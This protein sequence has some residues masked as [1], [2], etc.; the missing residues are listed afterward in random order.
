MKGREWWHSQ[1]VSVY[2][3]FQI[4]FFCS[5]LVIIFYYWLAFCPSVCYVGFQTV[6]LGVYIDQIWV[7]CLESAVRSVWTKRAFS[8]PGNWGD[9]ETKGKLSAENGRICVIKDD[10]CKG[11]GGCLWWDVEQLKEWQVGWLCVTSCREMPL[12]ANRI[13]EV[14]VPA[15]ASCT[16]QRGSYIHTNIQTVWM[17]QGWLLLALIDLGN[18]LIPH[19]SFS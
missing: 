13:R 11:G 6:V 19:N 10:Y 2:S 1:T 17:R 18:I 9:A 7:I 4:P 12:L 16:I 14:S 15:L 8:S 5:F 3:R